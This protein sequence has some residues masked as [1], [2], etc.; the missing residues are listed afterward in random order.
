[1]AD[2]DRP[3]PRFAGRIKSHDVEST[4][5]FSK[6]GLDAGVLVA[7]AR[8]GFVEPSPVQSQAI[9]VGVLGQDVLMQ[10]KSGTGKTV[11]FVSICLHRILPLLSDAADSVAR[12]LP[13]HTTASGAR[14][15]RVLVVSPTREIAVQTHGV[16]AQVARQLPA[17]VQA[18]SGGDVVSE[19][20]IGG[21]PV[22]RD[23]EALERGPIVCVGTPGRVRALLQNGLLDA[24]AIAVF[25]VDEADRM[26]EDGQFEED[27]MA[28]HFE[29]PHRKQVVAVSA[30]MTPSI[31]RQLTALMRDPVTVNLCEDT[32]ALEHVHVYTYDVQADGEEEQE[33]EE[34]EGEQEDN[35]K[36]DAIIDIVGRTAFNQAVVFWNAKPAACQLAKRLAQQ[37]YPCVQLS[38]AME[39]TRR[40]AAVQRMRNFRARILITSDL[41]ARGVDLE[42]VSLVISADIPRNDERDAGVSTLCHRL[43][44]TGRFGTVGIAVLVC[45]AS[46]KEKLLEM[47]K[48]SY[49]SKIEP[50][51]DE[52]TTAQVEYKM[53]DDAQEEAMK[54][55]REAPAMLQSP[56]EGSAPRQG[57]KKSGSARGKRKAHRASGDGPDTARACSTAEEE[58]GAYAAQVGGGDYNNS[59]WYWPGYA[60]HWPPSPPPPVPQYQIPAGLTM[61]SRL[62]QLCCEAYATGFADGQASK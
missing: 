37:G 62:W 13:S 54:T 3:L 11:A 10:A 28:I 22:P 55:L 27:L 56:K 4:T 20:F 50:L 31:Q 6:L 1:M 52:I 29:L 9:P 19:C 61:N 39:Q 18:E 41:A 46:E 59:Y 17:A 15:A 21:L 30:T 26:L 60:H 36:V 40:L 5:E 43:G 58:M 51:P 2:D 12:G 8:S 47:L 16:F 42:H 44:R 32:T 24:S 38:G 23:I 35:N 7:L 33:E 25:V 34:E 45:C 53:E 14:P 48:S 57:R 49:G